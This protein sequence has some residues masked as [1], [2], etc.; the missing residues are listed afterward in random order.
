MNRSMLRTLRG[1]L[2]SGTR[3]R[4]PIQTIALTS[5]TMLR[6]LTSKC[7]GAHEKI[8]KRP[9]PIFDDG[10]KVRNQLVL[11]LDDYGF[12]ETAETWNIDP[13]TNVFGGPL[14]RTAPTISPRGCEI[15]FHE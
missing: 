2:L 12:R 4:I 14:S 5:K 3:S 10:F 9:W 15:S 6:T 13:S 8:R 1:E 11:R 7:L